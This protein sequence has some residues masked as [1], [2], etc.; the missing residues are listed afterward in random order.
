M[1]HDTHTSVCMCMSDMATK[2]CQNVPPEMGHLGATE[3]DG[4]D[5]TSHTPIILSADQNNGYEVDDDAEIDDKSESAGS[6]HDLN[7]VAVRVRPVFSTFFDNQTLLLAR[8]K[9]KAVA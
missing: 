4:R 5:A 1:T 9:K 6:P 3:T 7:V 2:L 8:S